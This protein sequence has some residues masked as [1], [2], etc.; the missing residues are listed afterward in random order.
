MRTHNLNWIGVRVGAIIGST[1]YL[2][3]TLSSLEE[4]AKKKIAMFF[5]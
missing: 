1:F 3:V 5:S 4:A 2:L